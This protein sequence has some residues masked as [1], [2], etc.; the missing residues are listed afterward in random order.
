VYPKVAVY[1]GEG[2]TDAAENFVCRTPREE[3]HG[4]H[5]RR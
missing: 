2:S 3:K 5:H 1:K 4:H